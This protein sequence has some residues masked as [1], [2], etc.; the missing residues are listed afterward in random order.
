MERVVMSASDSSADVCSLV[1]DEEKVLELIE[2]GAKAMV[3]SVEIERA[4]AIVARSG[5]FMLVYL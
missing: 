5:N 2:G 1:E 4:V 3:G